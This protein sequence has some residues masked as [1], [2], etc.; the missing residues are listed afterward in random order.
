MS[1]LRNK[2]EDNISSYFQEKVTALVC[3][4]FP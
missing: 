3:F 1:Y 4:P 2:S